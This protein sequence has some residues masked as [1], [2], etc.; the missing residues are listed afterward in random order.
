MRHNSRKFIFILK[1]TLPRSSFLFRVC[2]MRWATIWGGGM[3]PVQLETAHNLGNYFARLHCFAKWF[4]KFPCSPCVSLVA[5][6]S[7]TC[8][9]WCLNT[10]KTSAD[11]ENY[12]RSA[13]LSSVDG[14]VVYCLAQWVWWMFNLFIRAHPRKS[15]KPKTCRRENMFL[16]KFSHEA[17]H[18]ANNSQISP[19][20]SR[21][22]VLFA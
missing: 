16:M 6:Q 13:T 21:A 14:R 10:P 11:T 8:K 7:H 18:E 12:T 1:K 17:H 20:A 9:L 15:R 22:I 5:R 19:L 4:R 3:E 2:F